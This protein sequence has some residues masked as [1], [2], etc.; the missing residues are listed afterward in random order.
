MCRR[1]F[2]LA[3]LPSCQWRALLDR[4]NAEGGWSASNAIALWRD[5]SG[6]LRSID[7]PR[8]SDAVLLTLAALET[9]LSAEGHRFTRGAGVDAAWQVWREAQNKS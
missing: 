1:V 4:S 5:D 2:H 7:A 9:V 6:R 3:P 8:N